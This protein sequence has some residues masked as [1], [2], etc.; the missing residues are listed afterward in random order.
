MWRVFIFQVNCNICH[1]LYV[2]NREEWSD[3]HSE[4]PQHGYSKCRHSWTL[5]DQ[6]NKWTRTNCLGSASCLFCVWTEK[7]PVIVHSPGSINGETKNVTRT[8]P[9]NIN[10]STTGGVY[11]PITGHEKGRVG[12]GGVFV[13]VI[14]L[15]CMAMNFWRRNEGMCIFFG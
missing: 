8:E 12:D 1:E 4:T 5:L 7:Y 14:A 10:Q 9:H 6:S 15:Q 3:T 13:I 2:G 11:Q